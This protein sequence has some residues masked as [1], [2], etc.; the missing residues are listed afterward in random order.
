ML[1]LTLTAN[2]VPAQ[3]AGR[4]G[5]RRVF[6]NAVPKTSRETV[7]DSAELAR[8]DSIHV[9]DSLH[10]ID[11]AALRSKS[12]LE[13]PAFSSAKDSIV[14]VFTDGQRMIYYYGDVT[15]E[16]QDMKLTAAYM[17]YNM[18]T[19]TVF[20]RGIY[21]SLAGEWVGRP[22][23]TQGGKTYNMDEVKYN[24]ETKKSSIKNI[25]TTEESALLHG[26][27]VKMM[28]DR[29]I[30]MTDGSSKLVKGGG[31]NVTAENV[32]LS[33]L[34]ASDDGKEYEAKGSFKV[35]SKNVGLI[36]M[37]YQRPDD[38]KPM[39]VKGPTAGGQVAL[40]AQKVTVNAF[41]PKDI[42]Y[43]DNGQMTK[44]E[45]EAS[46]DVIV[47]AKNFTVEAID[48][49]AK[50][51]KM[52]PKCQ[53]EG[54]SISLRTEKLNMLSADKDG[55]ATGSVDINAKAINLKTMD[56]DKE[57]LTDS[58]LAEG[59][60]MTIVSE[61]MYVGATSKDVKSKK[62]QMVS[63][64][65]GAFADNTLEMQQGD[66]KAVVQLDGGNASVGGSETQ[67]Y[68]GTTI[69]DKTEVKG[70]LKAPKVSGDSIEAKS[71][72]KS[73]NISDGMSAGAGGG[74][75]SLSAKLKAEDA[76]KEN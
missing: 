57:K 49:E 3:N 18:K 60:S 17:Q 14:E 47:R 7:L 67:I 24:F 48:Y 5:A 1:L 74:G 43:D 6:S 12:S 38:A 42:E 58:K 4:R 29:S 66:G 15:V 64:E 72:F 28:P 16:Y 35:L 9:A 56:V 46:G 21:D 65:I 33:S 63:E 39:T 45:I 71:A 30:N 62:L 23:M 10:R 54:S 70:E 34:E 55:K 26:G 76:P 69:N 32:T 22:V 40:T 59:G 61:K 73:P 11:S 8:R 44:G 51:G 27:K 19:G 13:M 75:G 41:T 20:A 50:D 31:L 52:A 37:D 53:T 2:I 68:G 36:A 25:L